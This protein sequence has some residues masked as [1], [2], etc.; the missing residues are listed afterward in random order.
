MLQIL[1]G[2]ALV[3]MCCYLGMKLAHGERLRWYAWVLLAGA[4]AAWVPALYFFLSGSTDWSSS[5]ALSRHRNHE[6]SVLQFYDSHDLWHMLSAMALYLTFSVLLTWDDGLSAVK[7]T[8]IP[9]F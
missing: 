7:R 3:H 5:P 4:A 6:C 8:D 9:V 1:L 2:N